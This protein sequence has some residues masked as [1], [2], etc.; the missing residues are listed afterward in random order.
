MKR[1]LCLFCFLFLF[2]ICKAQYYYNDIVALQQARIQYS[3]LKNNHIKTVTATSY[4]GNEVVTDFLLQKQVSSDANIITVNASYPSSGT[5]STVNT[6]SNDRITK[7]IDSKANVTTTTSYEYDN[8][9]RLQ[10]ITTNTTDTFMLS[11]TQEVHLW[12]YKDDKPEKMLRIKDVKDTSE[13]NFSYD[14]QGNVA[15]ET[16]RKKGKIQQAYYY[17][18]NA[19]KQLTDIV[20]YN[21]KAKKLLPDFIYEYDASGNIIQMTQVPSGSSD[22]M[23]WKYIYNDK[24]LKQQELLYT[25]QNQLVGRIEYTYQ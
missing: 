24:N 9:G 8:S 6:Y 3:A 11:Q 5:T 12:F 15:Q 1:L 19:V 22:Y 10:N 23:I 20:E 17:Y 21:N 4:E 14:E 7:S 2:F 25:K 13:I 18:Y 16:W